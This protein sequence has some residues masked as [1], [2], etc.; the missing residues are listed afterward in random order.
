MST[1]NRLPLK[2]EPLIRDLFEQA[3]EGGE[4]RAE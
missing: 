2:H 1:V 3:N 4:F